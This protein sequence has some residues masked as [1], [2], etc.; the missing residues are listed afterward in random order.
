MTD[1]KSEKSVSQFTPLQP[2]PTVDA[3]AFAAGSR[4]SRQ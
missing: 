4:R 1:N 2:D 3:A